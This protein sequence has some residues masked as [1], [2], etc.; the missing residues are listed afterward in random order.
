MS[1]TDLPLPFSARA[2]AWTLSVHARMETDRGSLRYTVGHFWL[3]TMIVILSRWGPVSS[4]NIVPWQY[5]CGR[6]IPQAYR[7]ATPPTAGFYYAPCYW[8]DRKFTSAHNFVSFFS[9]TKLSLEVAKWPCPNEEDIVFLY[10]CGSHVRNAA[11]CITVISVGVSDIYI[12]VTEYTLCGQKSLLQIVFTLY[13]KKIHVK[14]FI[15]WIW[16]EFMVLFNKLS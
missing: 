10:C 5:V 9:F 16:I 3:A 13:F 12:P 7:A 14:S 8:T 4:Q 2:H 1:L 11:I 6:C 15:R